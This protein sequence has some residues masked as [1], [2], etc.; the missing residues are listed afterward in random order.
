MKVSIII[1]IYNVSDYIERCLT[2][3]MVQTYKDIECILVD[4]CTPDDSIEKCQRMISEYQGNIEF[5]ILHHKRNRGLSAAR[6]TGTDA[7]SGEFIYYLDSDDEITSD[8]I[9]LMAKE[10]EGHPD[11]EIVMAATKSVPYSVNYDLPYYKKK[12]Y[13][14]DNDWV[15]YNFYK[16]WPCLQVNAWNKLINIKFVKN[17]Q[18]YFKEGIIHEDEM[19]MFMVAKKLNRLAVITEKTYIHY[20]NPDSIMGQATKERSAKN[21]EVIINNI[22]NNLDTP[23]RKLQIFKYMYYYFLFYDIRKKEKSYKR[24]LLNF[25]FA[26]LRDGYLKFSV[27]LFVNYIHE[28]WFSYSPSD[29]VMNYWKELEKRVDKKYKIV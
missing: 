12:I 29:L 25:S 14:D 24:L 3:V 27:Y 6:N 23:M 9:S 13:V 7:A 4:D 26:L 8:C 2:S 15:R 1:P 10:I 11:V 20:Y 17:N 5:I 19:W 22:I 28:Y 21:W 16:P 18:L